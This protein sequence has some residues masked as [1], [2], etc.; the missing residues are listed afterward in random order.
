M[1]GR[2]SGLQAR[3]LLG[4]RP[5]SDGGAHQGARRIAE[6]ERK[7]LFGTFTLGV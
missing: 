3:I 2:G 1:F 7:V 4:A 5:V 6:L